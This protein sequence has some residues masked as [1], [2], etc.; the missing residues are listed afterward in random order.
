MRATA[1]CRTIVLR[2]VRSSASVWTRSQ[3]RPALPTRAHEPGRRPRTIGRAQP[4]CRYRALCREPPPFMPLEWRC[5]A[6]ESSVYNHL[7]RRCES[8]SPSR[9][10]ARKGAAACR[11]RAGGEMRAGARVESRRR[12]TPGQTGARPATDETGVPHALSHPFPCRCHRVP[13][14]RPAAG[15]CCSQRRRSRARSARRRRFRASISSTPISTTAAIFAGR[16]ESRA[17][18]VTRQI[19]PQ[20]SAG[21]AL[22]YDYEDWKFSRPV[23]FG[24]VAP[25]SHLNAPNISVDLGYAFDSDLQVGISPLFGWA[26]ESGAKTGDALTYGAILAATKVFSPSLMLGAGV[27][28]VRQIDETKVFP[29]VDRATG[30]S[31]TGGGSA[32]RSRRVP[33]AARASN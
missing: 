21:L 18:S 33:R 29:F 10:V 6:I 25:W 4:L 12:E 27:G 7:E 22:R 31:T 15:R 9:R 1:S 17:G 16:P 14:R 26:F 3:A 24:G 32:T 5:V 23:A 2:P 11:S 8:P 28:V 13:R 30:R 20:F 19:T